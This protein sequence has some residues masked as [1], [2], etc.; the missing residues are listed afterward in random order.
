MQQKPQRSLFQ[1]SFLHFLVLGEEILNISEV[2]KMIPSKKPFTGIKKR[3]K[4]AGSCLFKSLKPATKKRFHAPLG[5]ALSFFVHFRL[6]RIF[7]KVTY[8]LSKPQHETPPRLK[9]GLCPKRP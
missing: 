8:Y 7:Q 3:N 6:F 1:A 5:F 4:K 2:A 9:K